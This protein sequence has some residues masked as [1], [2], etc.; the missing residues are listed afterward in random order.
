MQNNEPF[1]IK[2]ITFRYNGGGLGKSFHVEVYYPHR[3]HSVCYQMFGQ[4][5]MEILARLY[6]GRPNNVRW[7]VG[8]SSQR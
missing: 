2:S 4:D 6:R 5:E 7:G 3:F 1:E 8:F